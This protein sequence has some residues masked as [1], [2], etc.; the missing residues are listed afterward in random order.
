MNPDK[1]TDYQNLQKLAWC[2][3]GLVNAFLLLVMLWFGIS[4]IL[5][6]S[7]SSSSGM[8]MI[9]TSVYCLLMSI[10]YFKGKFKSFN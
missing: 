2:F 9:V 7:I 5:D 8:I 6:K 1:K 3:C 4:I 10:K